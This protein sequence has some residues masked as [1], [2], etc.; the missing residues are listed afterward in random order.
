MPVVQ[1]TLVPQVQIGDDL[2]EFHLELLVQS[3]LLLETRAH[4]EYMGKRKVND[5]AQST[6]EVT[7]TCALYLKSAESKLRL[8][9]TI[10]M[11]L[12]RVAHWCRWCGATPWFVTQQT[13]REL[14]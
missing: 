5:K 14:G 8:S 12:A 11:H 6:Q 1:V 2:I 10:R 4:R 13:T 7:A 3:V 9:S